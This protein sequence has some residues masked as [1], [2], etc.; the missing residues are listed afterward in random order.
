MSK[1]GV[2]DG[3]GYRNV[4]VGDLLAR[5]ARDVPSHEALV[6]PDRGL[7][8]DFANLEWLVRQVAKGLLSIGIERGDRVALWAP[9]VPEWIVLQFA[10]AKI[11]AVLV[12][13][14]TGLRTAEIEYLL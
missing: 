4:T 7:R 8:Y 6:Y 13:A 1:A 11:G 10:L 2:G 5:L 14:N 12:T 9:N 3:L